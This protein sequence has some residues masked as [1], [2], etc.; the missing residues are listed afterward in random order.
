MK[1]RKDHETHEAD[2]KKIFEENLKNDSGAPE[3]AEDH[4]SR[5]E[6]LIPEFYVNQKTLSDDSEEEMDRV[7]QQHSEESSEISELDEKQKNALFDRMKTRNKFFAKNNNSNNIN[8]NYNNKNEKSEYEIY[9]YN[10][11]NNYN[12]NNSLKYNNSG[13]NLVL[14]FLPTKVRFAE[15]RG[16]SQTQTQ[17]TPVR[18][19][20]TLITD[21][22]IK[23]AAASS[24]YRTKAQPLGLIDTDPTILNIKKIR[25]KFKVIKDMEKTKE[26]ILGVDLFKYDKK[27]WQKKN[28][29]E[30]NN[31][32]SNNF[33]LCFESK[34][35]IFKDKLC[36]VHFVFIYFEN[37]EYN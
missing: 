28:L 16:R 1:D 30:V 35:K 23:N 37:F 27:K 19:S 34:N 18:A 5:L 10:N 13:K 12:A 11:N 26:K 8:Y 6:R 25:E 17:T 2:K 7:S 32:Y 24:L 33:S 31:F 20:A 9:D 22:E 15:Q 36:D 3:K 29:R 4:R 14:P 21:F